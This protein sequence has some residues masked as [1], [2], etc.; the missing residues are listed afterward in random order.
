MAF[1]IG[2]TTAALFSPAG[3]RSKPEAYFIIDPAM[4][5]CYAA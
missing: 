5:Y 4:K 1:I 3:D 2:S